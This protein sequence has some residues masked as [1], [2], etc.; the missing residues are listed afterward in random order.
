MGSALL[1]IIF[2]ETPLIDTGMDGSALS[3]NI[4]ICMEVRSC[5]GLHSSARLGDVATT[6]PNKKRKVQKRPLIEC[7]RHPESLYIF[8]WG[9]RAAENR[10][11]KSGS[12]LSSPVIGGILATPAGFEP[13]TTGLEGRCSIQLSYGVVGST[14]KPKPLQISPWHFL[15]PLWEKVARARRSRRPEPDEGCPLTRPASPDSLSHKGRGYFSETRAP[16]GRT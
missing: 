12:F 11:A 7:P 9:S 8:H 6:V 13:A 14:Y 5:S 16:C 15:L 2:S 4:S 1:T 10:T 3:A